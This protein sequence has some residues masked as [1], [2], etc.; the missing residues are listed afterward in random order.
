MASYARR[1]FRYKECGNFIPKLVKIVFVWNIKIIDI[2]L[3]R[4]LPSIVYLTKRKKLSIFDILE[5]KKRYFFI[6]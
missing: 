4:V 5:N 1:A 6:F 2:R 3:V